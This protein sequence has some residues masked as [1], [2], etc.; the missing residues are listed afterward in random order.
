MPQHADSTRR[1]LGDSTLGLTDCYGRLCDL[2]THFNYMHPYFL[3][4][5][6]ITCLHPYFM[7]TRPKQFPTIF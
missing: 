6:H 1:A 2:M 7:K 5:L 4:R 3:Q